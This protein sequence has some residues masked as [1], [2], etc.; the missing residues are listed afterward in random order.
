MPGLVE[1]YDIATAKVTAKELLEISKLIITAVKYFITQ[2]YLLGIDNF[3]IVRSLTDGSSKV[4]V[5]P[6]NVITDSNPQE[7]ISSIVADFKEMSMRVDY[8]QKQPETKT[9]WEDLNLF[10]NLAQSRSSI[11]NIL[12]SKMPEDIDYTLEDAVI[13]VDE[14]DNII[15]TS[16]YLEVEIIMTLLAL[17]INVDSDSSLSQL[18]FANI[19]KIGYIRPSI[20]DF[21]RSLPLNDEEF[22]AEHTSMEN[23]FKSAEN[24]LHYQEVYNEYKRKILTQRTR[25]VEFSDFELELDQYAKPIS[26]QVPTRILKIAQGRGQS[27]QPFLDGSHWQYDT[28]I[29]PPAASGTIKINNTDFDASELHKIFYNTPLANITED[30]KLTG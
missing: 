9:L 12:K 14:L 26:V 2:N 15:H 10:F 16:S 11:G 20:F 29:K 6:V 8:D 1:Y 3:A 4:V 19:D 30:V 21:I 27:I 24:L 23:F 18:V 5:Y 28:I 13:N 17:D 7:T 22:D 25:Y